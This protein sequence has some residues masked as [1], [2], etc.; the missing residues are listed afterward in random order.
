MLFLS[1]L[2]PRD[3][4]YN[5]LK[6]VL[7]QYQGIK[8]VDGW[9]PIP[10]GPTLKKGMEDDRVKLVRNRLLATG[11]L[12]GTASMT[13]AI[14]NDV[15]NRDKAVLGDLNSAFEPAGRLVKQ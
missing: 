11:D 7:A 5:Q 13:S 8:N 9:Q 12:A 3:K 6:A 10:A 14:F 2:K 1:D 15:Y 4:F